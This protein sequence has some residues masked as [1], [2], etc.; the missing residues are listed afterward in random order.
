MRFRKVGPEEHLFVVWNATRTYVSMGTRT[1][2]PGPLEA[3]KDIDYTFGELVASSDKAARS[4]L[5]GL[6]RGM[7]VVAELLDRS[8][9]FSLPIRLATTGYRKVDAK[10]FAALCGLRTSAPEPAAAKVSP[11]AVPEL[12]V[13]EPVTV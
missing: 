8:R 11:I 5:A 4:V 1:L 3:P 10:T 2:K 12:V 13:P 7:L 9:P 6:T